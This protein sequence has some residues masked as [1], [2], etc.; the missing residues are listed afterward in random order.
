ME[1]YIK[2]I[3]VVCFGDNDWWYHN[4]GHMDIQLMR[5]FAKS[6][7]VLYVNSIVV[8]KFNVGEGTMFLRRLKRKLHSIMRGLK[9]SGIENMTVYSPFTMPVHHISGARRLNSMIL[10]FQIRRC[11]HKLTMNKPIVW[12]A[13][14]GAAETAVKLPHL[15]LV[16]QR[17]DQYEEM[18]G[19]DAEQIKRY[20]RLLKMH[21]DLVIY[22]NRDLMAREKSDCRKAVYLD[23]G[24]DY[25]VFADAHKSDRLPEEMKKIR[26]PVL[27]F[28]GG[29]DNH[30]SNIGLI[31]EV[32][33]L[34]PGVSVVLIGNASVDLTKLASRN[35]V[36]LFGQKPYEDIPHYAKCFDVCFMPWQQNEWIAAC[37]PV[38]LK[39]YLALGK[40][41]V[42]TSFSELAGYDGLVEVADDAASFAQ[43]VKKVLE[44]DC[45][46]LVLSRRNMVADQTWDSKAK[47]VLDTLLKD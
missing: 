26:H 2:K 3:D 36:Y 39:E 22:V 1:K 18:P 12:V 42:S 10:E 6:G 11:M 8:R 17:S 25:D 15:K 46:E 5:R 34:L 29:I 19:V 38:K 28:Y 44:K 4:H 9:P 40:P 30:T 32:A 33:D 27:G 41:I 23:H 14:P 7:R 35:N 47:A 16:Y 21:A 31:E 43:A 37:N 13:C 24:V 20:D 45:P